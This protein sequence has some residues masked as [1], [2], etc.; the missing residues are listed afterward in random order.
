MSTV[1]KPIIPC[2]FL[3]VLLGSQN[4]KF[5]IGGT[6]GVITTTAALDF[7]GGD[8]AFGDGSDP[9][10]LAIVATDAT[11]QVTPSATVS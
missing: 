4:T 5:A 3:I 8:M 7:E 1:F 6:S 10:L 2:S 9:A 11:G